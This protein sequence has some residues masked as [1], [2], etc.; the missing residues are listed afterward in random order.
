MNLVKVLKN[1]VLQI[2][3]GGYK[4]MECKLRC[5]HFPCV[6]RF[7]ALIK[8]QDKWFVEVGGVKKLVGM[9]GKVKVCLTTIATLQY[10]T[11]SKAYFYICEREGALYGLQL[12]CPC[13]PFLGW[14]LHFIILW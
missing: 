12:L 9:A 13:Y 1:G 14:V 11:A 5:R 6:C 10:V 8:M 4:S 3:I 7:T 2:Y